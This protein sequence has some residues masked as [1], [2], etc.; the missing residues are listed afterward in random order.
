MAAGKFGPSSGILLLDG[1]N[2]LSNKIS[3]LSEKATSELTDTTGLGDTAYETAPVGKTT[4]EV[5]QE[6]AFFDTTALYSHAAFSG[7][8]PTS[9]QATARIVCVGF[10]GQTTGYPFTGMEGAFTDSYEVLAEL[11]NLQKVNAS[12]AITGTRSAGLILQP[13]AVQ[14]D[15]WDTTSSPVD[16][17]ASSSAGGVGFIQCTQATGFSAFVGKVRHSADDTTY[18]DLLSFTDNVS[19][20]FAERKTVSGTVNRYLSFTGIISGTGSI[21]IFAGFSRG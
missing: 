17:A 10:A 7:S 1:Y 18:S 8:V 21:T 14:T 15:S 19:A 11:G 9:P 2:I 12:Y 16:N 4:M 20:P 6:G 13:L 5:T 3:S